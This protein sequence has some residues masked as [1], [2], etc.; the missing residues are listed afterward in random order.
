MSNVS[1][2]DLKKLIDAL[3]QLFVQ[4]ANAERA[5]GQ[6]RYMKNHF[7]FMGLSTETRRTLQKQWFSMLPN[8]NEQTLKVLVRMVWNKK[9]REFHYTALELANRYQKLLTADFFEDIEYMTRTKSWWDTVDFLAKELLGGLLVKDTALQ[10]NMDDWIVDP[11][12]WIR[13][14]AILYQ[15]N[16]KAATNTI[17][18]FEYCAIT[19]HEKDFFI[20][21]AI[22]WALR[23]YARTN[24]T[25]VRN[26]VE[27]NH[28][29]LS[30]LSKREALKYC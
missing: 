15:L 22:G 13:R 24:P 21:K 25:A 16:Y 12:M 18:L 29:S 23:H 7:I 20:R 4:H 19:M 11:A 3:E 30:G 28:V 10:K 5:V 2:L 8:L 9:E 17:K 1:T 27:K 6:A 14:S 26:F